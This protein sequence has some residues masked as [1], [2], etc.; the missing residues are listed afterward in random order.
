M[1]LNRVFLLGIAFLCAE[2]EFSWAAPRKGNLC[3][4]Q[5]EAFRQLNPMNQNPVTAEAV[6]FFRGFRLEQIDGL[7]APATSIRP[8]RASSDF[9]FPGRN[10]WLGRRI[11]LLEEHH[12]GKQPLDVMSGGILQG[13]PAI[14]E[15]LENLLTR[16]EQLNR[17]RGE[18]NWRQYFF[19]A[20][21][22]HSLLSAPHQLSDTSHPLWSFRVLSF[23]PILVGFN[24]D[25]FFKFVLGDGQ[26]LRASFQEM[27]KR[28]RSHPTD[29]TW[30]YLS[31]EVKMPA[32]L[33]DAALRGVE[34]VIAPGMQTHLVWEK[35]GM[36]V[37]SL[38]RLLSPEKVNPVWVAMDLLLIAEDGEW[39]LAM[40][41]RSDKKRPIVKAPA[42]ER[43][44]VP[45]K[46]PSFGLKPT[47]QP[48]PV[49]A[50]V[51]ARP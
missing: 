24:M 20:C 38:H 48:V 34:E 10:E 36:I 41:M 8:I 19:W 33:L 37:K 25:G 2:S 29:G 22:I 16:G 28:V 40:V 32:F 12:N 1:I 51:R 47:W 42:R 46:L 30:M 21:G 14:D 7:E 50:P 26:F 49:T 13:G 18:T 45:F 27:Q 23:L 4:A 3:V 15:F 17:Y 43:A 9:N 44:G 11:H 35:A 6:K 31:Y 5:L 39:K